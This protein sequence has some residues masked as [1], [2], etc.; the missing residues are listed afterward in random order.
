VKQNHPARILKAEIK[1]QNIIFITWIIRRYFRISE[2]ENV[3]RE[4]VEENAL[5]DVKIEIVFFDF[6]VERNLAEFY[7]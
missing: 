7:F 6:L 5:E 1:I 2:S 3:A 4:T